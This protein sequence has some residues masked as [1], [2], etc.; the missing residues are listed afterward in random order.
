MVKSSDVVQKA[1]YGGRGRD[2][3]EETF[4]IFWITEIF[5][6]RDKKDSV[7]T[8]DWSGFSFTLVISVNRTV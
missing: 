7:A 8:S 6:I 4:P 5:M 1:N 3:T 2:P